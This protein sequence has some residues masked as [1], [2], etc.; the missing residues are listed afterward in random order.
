MIRNMLRLHALA[1]VFALT[2]FQLRTKA[3]R[4]WQAKVMADTASTGTGTYHAAN[5]L[6]VT[7]DDTDPDDDNTSLA[8]EISSGTLTRGQ[9]TFAHTT[10]A[11][12]YTLTRT[13]T[14][15]DNYTLRKL[16][17]FTLVSGGVI[18]FESRLNEI[19]VMAPGDQIQLTSTVFL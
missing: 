19:A 8:G 1:L 14:S 18:V 6:G 12:S 5:Y 10:G 2:R 15:D 9:A 17:V 4:D 16:G 7:E 3:G 11:S 13:L